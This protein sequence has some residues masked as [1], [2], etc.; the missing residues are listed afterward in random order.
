MINAQAQ[1]R[2]VRAH[3][4][5]E[6]TAAKLVGCSALDEQRVVDER[7]VA[8][9]LED[10][11]TGSATHTD[12]EMAAVK[13]AEAH[14]RQRARVHEENAAHLEPSWRVE[15]AQQQ[16]EAQA[17]HSRPKPTSPLSKSTF[18]RTIS[19]TLTPAV[20]QHHDIHAQKT[21]SRSMQAEDQRQTVAHVAPVAT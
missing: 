21:A 20:T 6:H 19:A 16:A 7:A 11:A 12:G 2:E 9:L 4:H 17:A 10:H 13:R 14:E 5:G 15:A 18:A 8:C 3:D 1:E